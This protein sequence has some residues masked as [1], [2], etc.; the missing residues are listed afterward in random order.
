MPLPLALLAGTF[1]GLTVIAVGLMVFGNHLR[2]QLREEARAAGGP[3]F[4]SEGQ[5]TRVRPPATGAESRSK[6]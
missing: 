5:A 6:A 4:Y 3:S 1:G 2:K